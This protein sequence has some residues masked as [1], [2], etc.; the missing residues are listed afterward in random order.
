MVE[1]PHQYRTW[2]IVASLSLVV[3]A[4][5]AV[6]WLVMSVQARHEYRRAADDV[7]RQAQQ[8]LDSMTATA[9]EVDKLAWDR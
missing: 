7:G 5:C 1:R 6:G 3:M 9:E 4:A 2:L 8:A